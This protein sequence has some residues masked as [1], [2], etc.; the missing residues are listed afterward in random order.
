M[1]IWSQSTTILACRS[2]KW[3]KS[4]HVAVVKFMNANSPDSAE[5]VATTALLGESRG[6]PLR[7]DEVVSASFLL[8]TLLALVVL[9]G[10]LTLALRWLKKRQPGRWNQSADRR[11]RLLETLRTSPRTRISLLL[12]EGRHAVVTETPQGASLQFVP[13][14]TSSKTP[15]AD[16]CEPTRQGS[17]T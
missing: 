9:L 3:F 6:L 1:A 11:M 15:A 17:E 5:Q 13:E 4:F 14:H 7:R 12:I 8:E 2:R 16:I 10:A